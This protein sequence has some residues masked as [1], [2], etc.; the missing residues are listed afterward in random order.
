MD[1]VQVSTSGVGRGAHLVKQL[2]HGVADAV[3]TT[4]FRM[5]LGSLYALARAS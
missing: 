2:L 5:W 4:Y 3:G 1:A